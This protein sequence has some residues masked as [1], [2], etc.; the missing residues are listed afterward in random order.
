MELVSAW[1]YDSAADLESIRGFDWERDPVRIMLVTDRYR[2]SQA[3]DLVVDD[4]AH[5]EVHPSGSYE[6]GGALL[7]GRY[8]DRSDPLNISYYADSVQWTRFTG[9]FA[10]WVAYAETDEL[11]AYATLGAQRMTSGTVTLALS[12]GPMWTNRTVSNVESRLEQ[13]EQAR[14]QHDAELLQLLL[15]G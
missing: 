7:P 15:D 14:Q 3:D 8:V 12:A 13:R 10:Y 5:Y 1:L 4:V 2:P 9:A 11:I 6:R